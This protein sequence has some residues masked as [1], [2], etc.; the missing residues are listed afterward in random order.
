M[1]PNLECIKLAENSFF[2]YSSIYMYTVVCFM[3]NQNRKT[4]TLNISNKYR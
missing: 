1:G 3:N 4:Y 2:T